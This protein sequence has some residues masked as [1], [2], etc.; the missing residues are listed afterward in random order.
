[1]PQNLA[2]VVV[3]I[4]KIRVLLC[5][6]L[7]TSIPNS[8]ILCLHNPLDSDIIDGSVFSL[9][10]A[11]LVPLSL[12]QAVIILPGIPPPSLYHFLALSYSTSEAP[13]VLKFSH[14]SAPHL[15]CYTDECGPLTV[16]ISSS[17]PL[18]ENLTLPSHH[19]TISQSLLASTTLLI[20]SH[21]I[22]QLIIS[23]LSSQRGREAIRKEHLRA[24]YL[25]TS[26]CSPHLL[27]SP[28]LG[29]YSCSCSQPSLQPS[30]VRDFSLKVGSFLNPQKSAVISR[31][32]T[33]AS[34]DPTTLPASLP[35]FS[36]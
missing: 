15:F 5:V 35:P 6:Q 22:L 23:F 4:C 10:L 16:L 28:L 3:I 19:T 7:I 21:T 8:I 11:T 36:S 29:P 31:I 27:P 33:E 17:H 12:S 32:L 34:L 25:L 30:C 1:M 2:P 14:P 26:I 9:V 20:S 18:Q 13:A 24:P